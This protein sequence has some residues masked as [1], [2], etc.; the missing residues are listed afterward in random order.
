MLLFF[1]L[2]L[3][4]SSILRDTDFEAFSTGVNN[5]TNSW[6][7]RR[8]IGDGFKISIDSV[9]IKVLELN[10]DYSSICQ[11]FSILV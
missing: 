2:S 6:Y 3:S 1:V 11:N 10:P 4:Y 8:A 5:Y 9:G 7:N